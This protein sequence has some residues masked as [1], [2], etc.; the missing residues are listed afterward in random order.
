MRLKIL[1]IEDNDDFREVVREY[2]QKENFDLAILEA[3]DG[4]LGVAIALKEKPDIVLTDIRMEGLNGLEAASEIKQCLPNCTVIALTMF[5]TE[6]FRKV[7]KTNDINEYIGK[8]ELYE[9]LIPT[10]ER[11]IK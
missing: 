4:D 11:Y 2:I 6:S 8:S 7:F 3:S 10:L 1:I 5:E 9:K